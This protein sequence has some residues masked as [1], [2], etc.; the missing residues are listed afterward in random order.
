[1]SFTTSKITATDNQIISL[2]TINEIEKDPQLPPN[3]IPKELPSLEQITL[4]KNEE[5]QNKLIKIKEYQKKYYQLNKDKLNERR[6]DKWRTDGEYREY[7]LTKAKDYYHNNKTTIFNKITDDIRE[8]RRQYA[9]EY[10]LNN[11]ETIS[12]KSK[13]K[14]KNKKK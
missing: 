13:A 1:M 9:K 6:R 14:R 5:Y 7:K 12:Q 11:K 10:Y 4:E 3:I 2:P 8:R